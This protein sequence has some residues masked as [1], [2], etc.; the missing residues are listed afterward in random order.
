MPVSGDV[1]SENPD[2]C[3]KKSAREWKVA[4]K[5]IRAI[6]IGKVRPIFAHYASTIGS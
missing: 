4:S 2:T 1:A 3:N 5:V 6:L